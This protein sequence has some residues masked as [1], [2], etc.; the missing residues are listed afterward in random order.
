MPDEIL[1]D[2]EVIVEHDLKIETPEEIS[3]EELIASKTPSSPPLEQRPGE[4]VGDLN[5][6]TEEDDQLITFEEELISPE[7]PFSPP[8]E[9]RPNEVVGDFDDLTEEVVNLITSDPGWDSIFDLDGNLYNSA[10]ECNKSKAL[11][12]K[13]ISRLDD[14]EI[15]L[16][17]SPDAKPSQKHDSSLFDLKLDVLSLQK[18]IETLKRQEDMLK[19]QLRDKDL[20]IDDLRETKDLHLVSEAT[21][22]AFH[23]PVSSN[24]DHIDSWSRI[25]HIVER[26]HEIE[27]SMC[28]IDPEKLGHADVILGYI[29]DI[30]WPDA[31]SGAEPPL[32]S[33]LRFRLVENDARIAHLREVV[34]AA[35]RENDNT[36]KEISTTGWFEQNGGYTLA[37]AQNTQLVEVML[38]VMDESEALDQSPNERC[39]RDYLKEKDL[40]ITLREVGKMSPREVLNISGIGNARFRRTISQIENTG[41]LTPLTLN[42]SVLNYYVSSRELALSSAEILSRSP[43]SDRDLR[44]RHDTRSLSPQ[45]LLCELAIAA[46]KPIDFSMPSKFAGRLTH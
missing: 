1:C 20:Q 9:K 40:P 28:M 45:E 29:E 26:L 42:N 12:G 32:L 35:I 22:I 5:D 34:S 37:M 39:V 21:K 25:S 17:M 6:L 30:L 3:E 16:F 41:I 27:K 4:A 31:V 43:Y 44:Y 19:A 18:R 24:E 46:L 7:D 38:K 8:L 2:S 15:D 36:R 33:A 10:E 14:L 11:D 23:G 13:A